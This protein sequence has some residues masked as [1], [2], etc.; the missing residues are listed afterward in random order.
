MQ[1]LKPHVFTNQ[2]LPPALSRL[3]IDHLPT[4][5]GKQTSQESASTGK[6]LKYNQAVVKNIDCHA[7]SQAEGY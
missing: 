5:E 1:L 2:F 7:G 6:R 4:Q 3:T